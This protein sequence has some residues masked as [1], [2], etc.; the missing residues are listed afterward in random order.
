MRR[1][2]GLR[3]TRLVEGGDDVLGEV[4][5]EP[6]APRQQTRH[7]LRVD[8]GCAVLAAD[9]SD[10]QDVVDAFAAPRRGLGQPVSGRQQRTHRPQ[11]RH[12]CEKVYLLSVADAAVTDVDRVLVKLC[13]GDVGEAGDPAQRQPLAEPGD[14][15]DRG[16]D[17]LD[18]WPGRAPPECCVRVQFLV[19]QQPGGVLDRLTEHCRD[20]GHVQGEWIGVGLVQRRGQDPPVVADARQLAGIGVGAQGS[21]CQYQRV[22]R[23]PARPGRRLW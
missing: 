7:G 17:G 22:R 11:P 5:D 12:G 13:R 8:P 10:A 16:G 14:E 19:E 9:G 23:R 6:Q 1:R 3:L 21:V 20:S 2:F 4:L 15:P 18:S